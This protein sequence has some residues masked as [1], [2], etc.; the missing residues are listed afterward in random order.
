MKI[1]KLYMSACVGLYM[2]PSQ[3]LATAANGPARLLPDEIKQKNAFDIME[4]VMQNIGM[5][6]A[7][8]V[9]IASLIAG[10]HNI[11]TALKDY[12]KDRDI[13]RLMGTVVA[14][15]IVVICAVVLGYAADAYVSSR[16]GS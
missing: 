16:F 14:V 1:K 7:A 2:L 9:I 10:G 8:F 13:G 3:V 4:F 5:L 6:V 15:L 12:Q 11:T